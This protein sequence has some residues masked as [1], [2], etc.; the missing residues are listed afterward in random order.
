MPGIDFSKIF[1]YENI[2]PPSLW[3]EEKTCGWFCP[4]QL[5]HAKKLTLRESSGKLLGH[6]QMT[7]HNN[8]HNTNAIKKKVKMN[9]IVSVF[10]PKTCLQLFLVVHRGHQKCL[11]APGMEDWEKS[12][13]TMWDKKKHTIKHHRAV[14]KPYQV[15][16]ANSTAWVE[17]SKVMCTEFFLHYWEPLTISLL[18]LFLL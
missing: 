17:H 5:P 13:T 3:V 1:S 6:I 12:E 16:L 9:L 11:W 4:K 18:F 2:L 10:L 15:G 14:T 8:N 7:G